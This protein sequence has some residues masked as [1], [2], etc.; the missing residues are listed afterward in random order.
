MQLHDTSKWSEEEYDA[1]DAYFY[2]KSKTQ[3]VKDN[4]IMLGYITFTRIHI[5]GNTGY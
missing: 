1:Y 4:L 5:T 3:E 2:G